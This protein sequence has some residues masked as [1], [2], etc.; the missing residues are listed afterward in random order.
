MNPLLL[1]LAA[2]LLALPVSA[3][4]AYTR[5]AN[6]NWT[7]D[8]GWS[9][10]GVPGPG[11]TADLGTRTVTLDADVT[12]GV[13]LLLSPSSELN[14]AADLVVTDTLRWEA[15]TSSATGTLTVGPGA[16]LR[17][18][19]DDFQM[20]S[21]GVLVNQGQAVW[22]APAE[23]GSFGRF[24]NEGQLDLSFDAA[25][26]T[27]FCFSSTVDAITNGPTGLIR[28][29]GTGEATIYC[30]FSNAGT[31]RVES[32]SLALRGFGG[33]GGTDTG[34]YEVEA[35]ATL[36]FSGGTR[37]MTEAVSV[38]GD[39][40]VLVT[41]GTTTIAGSFTP[42]VLTSDGVSSGSTATYLN[43]NGSDAVV[44][45]FIFSGG[46]LGG[47]GTLTVT[48]ALDWTEGYMGSP[49]QGG[50][51]TVV[52]STATLSISGDDR[53]GIR[54]GRTLRNEGDG[55]WSG[56]ENLNNGGDAIFLNAGTLEVSAG[57]TDPFG[58]FFGDTFTN[59]GT[60]TLTSGTVT[61]FSSFFHNEGTVEVV[62]GALVLSGF[63]A[64]GGI[65]TGRYVVADS[66]RLE[67]TGGTRT[68][69]DTAEIAGTGA[70]VAG[71]AFTN[72][73]TWQPGASPGTLTV[74]S[75]YPAGNGV[76]E[77]ELGGHAPGTEYDVLAVSSTAT[78]GGTLRVAL[79]DD[80]MP[81]EGNRFTVLTAGAV[82]GTFAALD[83]PGGV[84]ATVETTDTTAVLVIGQVVAN[85]DGN[86]ALP[87]AFALHA[88]Y[89][90]PF[91]TE[92]I[93]RYDVPNAALVRVA[94]YDV[95]G[96]EVAVLEDAE[97]A[98]GTHEVRLDGGALASG[99]YVVRMTA[100]GFAQTQRLVLAR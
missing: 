3:Q 95:L 13:L 85:E 72:G 44:E 64:N 51:T 67:F 14:G 40:E 27:R 60:F 42:R 68:L 34:E 54:Y 83:L 87:T 69:T 33:T 24:V 94:L 65:D 16:T 97:R 41:G 19:G 61:R 89:P 50:G 70:V 80:F 62:S 59:T 90:N 98:G 74:E 36:V 10:T 53:K 23:W 43:L 30:G 2:I 66:A 1:V 63:N 37:T 47:S 38:T 56:T 45:T 21:G 100:E 84:E 93:L 82:T 77:I 22:E 58:T 52:A 8:A 73:A 71:G 11:D 55:T 75:D 35:G 28:R 9:P 20:G 29:T 88:A 7:D 99:L 46:I 79:V 78:L 96:R 81:Q 92:A 32:G 57:T 15:G 86:E 31:V 91:T 5:V 6:G 39:G 25:E 18:R 17:L 76:L 48:D 26:P 4:T 12:V 49:L